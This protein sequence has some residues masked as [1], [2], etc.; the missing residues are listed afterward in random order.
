MKALVITVRLGQGLNG[1]SVR[2]EE[3][4]DACSSVNHQGEAMSRHSKKVA[5]V[6]QGRQPS[7]GYSGAPLPEL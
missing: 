3:R 4:K 7:S 2:V 6:S 1:I 5:S